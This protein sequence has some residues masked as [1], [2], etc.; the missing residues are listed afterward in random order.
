MC[1]YFDVEF[2]FIFIFYRRA[3]PLRVIP[4]RA[5]ESAVIHHEGD[6][7]GYCPVDFLEVFLQG[8][9]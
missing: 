2:L 8:A 4:A 6:F 1:S 9:L 3:K 5:A 7:D